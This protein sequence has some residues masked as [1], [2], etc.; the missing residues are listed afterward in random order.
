MMVC[1]IL[2]TV[3]IVCKQRLCFQCTNE[4]IIIFVCSRVFPSFAAA[5]EVERDEHI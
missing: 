1:C 3:V 4:D 2:P 5:L